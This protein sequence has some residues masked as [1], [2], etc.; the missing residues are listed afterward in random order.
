MPLCHSMYASLLDFLCL[1]P[2]PSLCLCMSF[3]VSGSSSHSV[4]LSLCLF[5]YLW[6]SL[7]PIFLGLLPMKGA[8]FQ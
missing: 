7:S 6:L 5:F 2:R 4:S 3:S 1:P 8:R